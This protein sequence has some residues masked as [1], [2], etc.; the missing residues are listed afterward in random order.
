MLA[1][2]DHVIIGV[3]GEDLLVD[4]ANVTGGAF[5]AQP[6]PVLGARTIRLGGQRNSGVNHV[7]NGQGAAV[8]T[9]RKAIVD[10]TDPYIHR[11]GTAPWD[12]EDGRFCRGD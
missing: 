10:S 8:I 6:R 4:R 1:A 2:D 11:H 7:I 5:G 12:P 3:A 9:N